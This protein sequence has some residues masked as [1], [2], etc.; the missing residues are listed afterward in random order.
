MSYAKKIGKIEGDICMYCEA[1]DIP[2][3]TIFH[4]HRWEIE[5]QRTWNE[6]GTIILN[7]TEIRER[8]AADSSTWEAIRKLAKDIISTKEEDEMPINAH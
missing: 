2:A 8:M 7:A 6:I 4:C 1:S 3:H 5:I